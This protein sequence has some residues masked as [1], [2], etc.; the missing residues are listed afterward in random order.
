MATV[1]AA[2]THL[3]AILVREGFVSQEEAQKQYGVVLD[4]TGAANLKETER[5]RKAMLS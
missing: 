2:D 3:G 4:E 5:C 1:T